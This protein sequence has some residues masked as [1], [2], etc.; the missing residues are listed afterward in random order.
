MLCF[1]GG[2]VWWGGVECEVFG[3]GGEL[4]FLVGCGIEEV[5]FFWVF[6]WGCVIG[7]VGFIFVGGGV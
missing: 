5:V 3:Y 7:C 1:G 6:V 4:G 2:V